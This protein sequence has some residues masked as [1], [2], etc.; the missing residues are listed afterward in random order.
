VLIEIGPDAHSVNSLDNT[1]VG[2]GLARKGWLR[3]ED[4]LNTGSTK[5]VLAFAKK[6]RDR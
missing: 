5:E 6:K 2:V 3:A 1:F 4:V